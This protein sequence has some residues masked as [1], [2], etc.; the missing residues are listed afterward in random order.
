MLVTENRELVLHRG[1]ND[2]WAVV[3]GE[4][5]PAFVGTAH[6]GINWACPSCSTVLVERAHPDQLL[7]LLVRCHACPTLGALPRRQPGQP[8][9]MRRVVLGLGQTRIRTRFDLGASMVVGPQADDGYQRETGQQKEA[10]AGESLQ[11]RTLSS[12]SLRELAVEAVALLGNQYA[13]LRNSD[14]RGQLSPTPPPRRHRLI[15]LIMSAESAADRIENQLSDIELDADQLTEL[16]AVVSMYGRWRHHP[17]MRRLVQTLH[18]GD[19]VQHSSMLLAVASHFVDAGHGVGLVFEDSGGPIPDAWVQANLVD[20][21]SLEIKTP[22][23]LRGP[24]PSPLNLADSMALVTRPV[25]S[26]AKSRGRQHESDSSGILVIGGFH[27]DAETV[28]TLVEARSRILERQQHRKRHLAA[29]AFVVF[30]SN[31]ASVGMGRE[32][33][34]LQVAGTL[35]VRVVL[36]PGYRGDLAVGLDKPALQL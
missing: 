6:A 33:Q 26:V 4:A 15:E 25:A 11:T 2:D 1:P 18:G 22:L 31:I 13:D 17:A 5:G 30:S 28:D 10:A 36:H 12:A 3:V 19:E 29:L 7:D 34:E 35:N 16:I 21:L 23:A 24:K 32:Y 8:L 9:T 27:L 20:R 14:L